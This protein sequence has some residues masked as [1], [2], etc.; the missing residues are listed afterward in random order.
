[1]ETRAKLFDMPAGR[2]GEKLSLHFNL[3]VGVL[4]I[5][6]LFVSPDAYDERL[7]N[8]A[9][10]TRFIEAVGNRGGASVI[11]QIEGNLRNAAAF[12]C[13]SP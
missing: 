3:P 5:I 13:L 7:T 10:M 11:E 6:S 4:K 8:Q 2:A 9:S 1:M 12:V